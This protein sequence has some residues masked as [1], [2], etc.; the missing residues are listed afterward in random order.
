MSIQ[1]GALL[2]VSVAGLNT[3][4]QAMNVWQYEVTNTMTTIT[5]ENVAEAW[6]NH[7][8]VKYRAIATAYYDALFRT[9]LVRELNAPTG[10]YGTYSIPLA[11]QAGTRSMGSSPQG[12]PPF[13]AVAARLNV[14]TRV[15]R[16]GQKRF[17]GL[18][19]IDQDNGLLASS[20][21]SVAQDTMDFMIQSM[22]LGVPAATMV[23]KPV[24]CRKDAVGTVTA[25]Q[26]IESASIGL[27]VS[28]QNSRKF[29]RGM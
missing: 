23:L 25:H 20:V 24:V 1:I 9:V 22:T 27:Y 18:L 21:A 16:P 10:A 26:G 28:T 29:G 15:T 8:K 17:A 4:G 2:E 14:G 19:E 7:V 5:G 13:C 11:E 6:W 3:G 12:L